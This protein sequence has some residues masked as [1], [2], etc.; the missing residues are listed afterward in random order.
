MMYFG[1]GS[2]SAA[3]AL[4]TLPIDSLAG[5]SNFMPGLLLPLAVGQARLSYL[6]VIVAALFSAGE[7]LS[8]SVPCS[9][10]HIPPDPAGLVPQ[11]VVKPNRTLESRVLMTDS[12]AVFSVYQEVS[13]W[14]SQTGL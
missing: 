3:S 2:V 8:V 10:G 9:D 14:L 13:I 11:T 12:I 5:D 7:T 6:A 4:A 1:P